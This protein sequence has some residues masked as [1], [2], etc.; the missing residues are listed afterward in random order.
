MCYR[1]ARPRVRSMPYVD[2]GDDLLARVAQ[3]VIFVSLVAS[4]IME[5]YR[6]KCAQQHAHA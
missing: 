6:D 1:A 2:D 5:Q 4:I 3:I